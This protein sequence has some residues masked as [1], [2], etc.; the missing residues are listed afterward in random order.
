MHE[1]V[2]VEEKDEIMALFSNDPKACYRIPKCSYVG[3]GEHHI[4]FFSIEAGVNGARD[5][6]TSSAARKN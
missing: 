3:L 4:S 1:K 2:I 6:F 5:A